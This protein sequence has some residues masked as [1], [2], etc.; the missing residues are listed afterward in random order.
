[1]T[2]RES[3]EQEVEEMIANTPPTEEVL[4]EIKELD[5]PNL[6]NDPEFIIG[7]IKGQIVEDILIVMERENIDR[8]ELAIRL[9]KSR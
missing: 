9:G 2:N 1:M 5:L 7:V 3:I 4:K 6:D 8:N